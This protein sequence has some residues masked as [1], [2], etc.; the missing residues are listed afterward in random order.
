MSLVL[1]GPGFEESASEAAKGNF[2]FARIED[3]LIAAARACGDKTAIVDGDIVLSYATLG[4]AI[5]DFAAGLQARG[6]A[7]GDRVSVFLDK[8][9]QCVISL[10]GSWLAGAIVVPINEGLRSRQVYHILTNSGSRFLVTDPRK[11]A[12]LGAGSLG[13]TMILDAAAVAQ[14]LQNDLSPPL[15]SQ[16][17]R[18]AILYTSGSTGLPK[19]ILISH[20]NLLAGS[21]IVARYL[22]LKP[23]ERIISLVPFS[24][25]YGLNQLLTAVYVT[26]T[27]VL[28]RSLFPADICRALNRHEITDM[29]A[30]PTLW[31]Q[32]LQRHSPF[33]QMS[34]PH[35]R[36]ITNTGGAFP[37]FAVKRYRE[38]LPHVR[39]Y[40]M[41][42]LS[43]SF[44]SSYLPPEYVDL[45]PDSMGRAIPECELFV[46]SA[47]GNLCAPG[48]VGELVHRG[49]TVALGYWN[50]PEATA[51]VFRPDPFNPSGPARPVV[52]SG[53]L[54]KADEKGLLF[55]VSRRDQMIKSHGFRISPDEVERII[56][57]SGMVNEVV[58]KGTPDE[59]AGA[60][61]V[62]HCVPVSAPEFSEDEFLRYCRLE[63]PRYMVPKSVH[64]HE[65]FPRTAS[66]KIDRKA[67]GS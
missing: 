31:L 60:V 23:D 61:V 15:A 33:A 49:P 20:A 36:Y 47:E 19:G 55:F 50:D 14:P 25:D 42:G 3:P 63:M 48:E 17:K 53:D 67:V 57:Q 21:R 8:T 9:P 4:K 29:A 54:V 46:V 40:L 39:L 37:V 24:F 65:S 5:R 51:K 6:L 38:L 28:H 64:L 13:S 22:E 16:D 7:P 35:L 2:A 43:E 66:G 56:L 59:V 58:V 30:V 1:A 27:L 32:L 62:A 41:Y 52:Y 11:Q 34:F 18:A 26:G 44:R 12:D 10:Y 45:H